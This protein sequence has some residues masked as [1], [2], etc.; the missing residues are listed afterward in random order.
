GA[1]DPRCPKRGRIRSLGG[2]VPRD[3]AD[4][5]LSPLESCLKLRRSRNNPAGIPR[6]RDLPFM[7]E[8]APLHPLRLVAAAEHPAVA[9]ACRDTAIPAQL[10]QTAAAD[11]R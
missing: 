7:V 5:R 6:A 10:P 4:S 1:D 11:V 2:V 8:G 9:D 3:A